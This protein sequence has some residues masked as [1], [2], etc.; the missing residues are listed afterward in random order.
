MCYKTLHSVYNL[1]YNVEKNGI[2]EERLNYAG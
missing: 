2:L 1:S